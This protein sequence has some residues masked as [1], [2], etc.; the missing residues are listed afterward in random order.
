MNLFS[1][2]TNLADKTKQ[3]FSKKKPVIASRV[4][5]AAVAYGV[6]GPTQSRTSFQ[7]AEYNLG[8]ISKVMDIE[9]YVRQAFN[10]H[11]ELCLKEGYDVTSRNEEATLYIKRRLREM[12]EVSGHT[13]DMLLRYIMQNIVAY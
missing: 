1:I 13:F 9:A 3:N 10:K 6:L 5:N 2:S 8:E 12:S 7:V 4:P 11:V